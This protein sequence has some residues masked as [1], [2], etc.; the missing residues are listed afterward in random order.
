[1][2]AGNAEEQGSLQLS[3]KPL[4]FLRSSAALPGK[5]AAGGEVRRE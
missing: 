5:A 3:C 2:N 1:M 4:R